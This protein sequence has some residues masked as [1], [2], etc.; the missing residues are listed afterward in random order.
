[1]SGK[2]LMIKSKSSG[3]LKSFSAIQRLKGKKE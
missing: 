1:L 2:V 3:V